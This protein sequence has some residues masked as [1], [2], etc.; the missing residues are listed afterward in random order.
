MIDHSVTQTS[1]R[2]V[3]AVVLGASGFIGRWVARNLCEQ[4]ARLFLIIRDCAR[5]KEIF[6]RYDIHGEIVEIDLT[7]SGALRELIEKIRPSITFNLAG[8]GVDRSERDEELAYR[9]NAN[10]IQTL[11]EAIAECRDDEWPGQHLIHTGSALEYGEIGGDLAEDSQ[12]APTTLYGKSKLAGTLALARGC[13][14]YRIKG[15]TARLFTVYGPGEHEG[16][17]LPSLLGAAQTGQP[18]QLTEGRQQRDFTY[19]AEVAEGLLRLGLSSAPPGEI[20]NLATGRLTTVRQFVETAAGVLNIPDDRLLFG[21]APT[22]SEE[23]SHA[24]VAIDRLRRLIDWAPRTSISDGV[25]SAWEFESQLLTRSDQGG[26][27]QSG[28]AQNGM[29]TS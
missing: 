26:P 18:I 14:A 6:S 22:R 20:A 7:H 15:V 29:N 2:G 24:P 17:L 4:G 11:C 3:R 27:P 23:M 10:L 12:P 19:V 13:Q 9:I 1:Y 16:R 8:Y 28:M 25:R 5:A 21:A